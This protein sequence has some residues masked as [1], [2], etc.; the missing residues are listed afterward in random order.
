MVKQPIHSGLTSE[1]TIRAAALLGFRRLV[2]DTGGEPEAFLRDS[3]IDPT[4]LASPDNRISYAAMIRMLEDCAQQLD[5]PNF[6]LRLSDYQD[7]NILGP[8]A[9]IAYYSDT[10]SEALRAITT[11]FYVHTTAA[12]VQLV[13]M[14]SSYTLLTFEVLIP[15]LHARAQINELSIGIGQSLLNLLT[16][17]GFHSEHVQF[18]HSRPKDLRPLIRR[19]G[20]H[21]Q[22][23]QSLNSLTLPNSVLAKPVSTA[24]PEFRKIAIDY[25]RDHLGGAEDN[26]VRRVVLLVHQ[27]LPT[28]RCSLQNVADVL[29]MH[30]RT[31]QREL[32]SSSADFRGIVDRTRRELVTDYLLETRAT[33]SQVSA[34]LGYSDQAAFNNAFQRWYGVPPGRWRKESK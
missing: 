15:G 8:A 29:G 23:E 14:D 13:R 6:G 27:L 34:M 28:G 19:F 26:R 25:V 5:C 10:V 1:G 16:G 24:N 30:P 12:A 33:L 7:M 22:F 18:T 3:G 31:L 2:R 4:A 9:L 17:P 21:L 32:R 11:Y 20:N